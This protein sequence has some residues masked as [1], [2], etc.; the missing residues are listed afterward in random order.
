MLGLDAYFL[1]SKFCLLRFNVHYVHWFTVLSSQPALSSE[2]LNSCGRGQNPAQSIPKFSHQNLYPND[3]PDPTCAWI[4]PHLFIKTLYSQYFRWPAHQDLQALAQS[5]SHRPLWLSGSSP[6]P[7]GPCRDCGA[8]L[9]ANA[10]PSPGERWKNCRIV[11]FWGSKDVKMPR[12]GK[13]CLERSRSRLVRLFQLLR[14]WLRVSGEAQDHQITFTALSLGGSQPVF[15]N[16]NA[17]WTGKQN[18]K[19]MDST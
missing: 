16:L 9:D 18:F 3:E 5:E 15:W 11:V 4:F 8:D 7:R 14:R 19:A 2:V 10:W 1:I 6:W 12:F 17:S 13:L